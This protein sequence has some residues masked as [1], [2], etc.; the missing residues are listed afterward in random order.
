[1]LFS[2]AGDHSCSPENLENVVLHSTWFPKVSIY[3]AELKRELKEASDFENKLSLW[4]DSNV[5]LLKLDSEYLSRAA[6]NHAHFPLAT[7]P[8]SARE[9]LADFLRRSTRPGAPL[10]A[11]AIYSRYHLAAMRYA[12]LGK[13]REAVLSEAFAIHFLEDLFSAGHYAGTWGDAA[14]RKGTHDYYS[15][16]GLVTQTW[17]K[18]R[19]SGHGDASMTVEDAEHASKA[20]R[21]SLKEFLRAFSSRDVGPRNDLPT[22][23]SQEICRASRVPEM[24]LLA[25]EE[26]SALTPI[27]YQ[28]PIPSGGEGA[29]PLPRFR[30]ET[31]PFVSASSGLRFGGHVGGLSENESLRSVTRLELLGR[32]G[33]G[34]VGVLSSHSDGA[35]F[36][37]FGVVADGSQYT[38][39]QLDSRSGE[40]FG[41]RMPFWLVPGD[42]FVLAPAFY[43]IDKAILQNIAIAAS[44]GGLLGLEKKVDTPIGTLQLMAG[45]QIAVSLFGYLWNNAP[46]ITTQNGATIG[47]YR[48][49][50][51]DFPL[52]EYKAGHAFS[53]KLAFDAAVQFGYALELPRSVNFGAGAPNANAELN[54]SSTV[55]LRFSLEGSKYW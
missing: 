44:N 1:M 31:G 23:F 48:S 38:N 34:T 35:I 5:A 12:R 52:V 43:F 24:T 46:R 17:D 27:L 45:R 51:I 22:D 47:D 28:V 10:N 2:L 37:E 50:E 3:A 18:E 40:R 8:V 32:L 33:I 29:V 53:S 41:L 9:T 26:Q 11:V 6:S 21:D 20:V 49:I 55:Y 54:A 13:P 4:N 36:I 25:K 14:E 42:L 19:Y 39:P 16:N 7:L 15:V 30:I